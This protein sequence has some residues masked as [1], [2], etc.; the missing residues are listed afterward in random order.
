MSREMKDS[1]T[2][3]AGR[4]PSDWG[5]IKFSQAIERMSTGLNPRDNFQLTTEDELFYV[6]I[7]NF[8]NGHIYLNDNCDR[9]S[10]DA[11]KLIQSRSDIKKGDVLF[12]SISDEPNAY[13]IDIDVDNWNINESVFTIRCNTSFFNQKY[14]YY[15]ITNKTYYD[16]L[17]MDATGSTFKS[18]KQNKLLLSQLIV[19]PLPE[20]QRIADFLDSKC[21]QIDEISKK[22][23]EE[24][25]TLEE[26]KKSV[27]TE[28][29]TKGLDPNVEMKDSGIEWIGEIPA[30]W[31]IHP[32]FYYYGDENWT[33]L[34][35]DG[36]SRLY[37]ETDE[38]GGFAHLDEE[39][40]L[41][42]YFIGALGTNAIWQ[43][44]RN[45]EK[46]DVDHGEI[47][48]DNETM[49][50]NH[51]EGTP[52]ILELLIDRD[53]K[54]ENHDRLVK[55]MAGLTEAQR[56]V[57]VLRYWRELTI[58][59]IARQIGRKEESVKDRIKGAMKSLKK[60]F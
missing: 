57:I 19:P 23:Q 52:D 10:R 4:I 22:I 6:T 60:N 35:V 41:D 53:L 15:L 24:I 12:A 34:R 33:V 29:V 44:K 51:D 31:N 18:I 54:A 50:M 2:S 59:E 25:D 21:S 13:L 11:W 43:L 48:V 46:R 49:E 37:Y 16:D 20:Q 45:A 39:A 40:F 30:K 27:I 17:R 5:R 28:A 47:S 1:G 56:E 3:W 36:F 32:V 7:R 55:A 8:K 26:Y 9:I 58:P 14:F 42:E 38:D